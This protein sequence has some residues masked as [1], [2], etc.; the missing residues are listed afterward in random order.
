[1]LA[2]RLVA[3]AL[4]RPDSATFTAS[5]VGVGKVGVIVR[6]DSGLVVKPSAGPAIGV[7]D[8]GAEVA[9]WGGGDGV[10][11]LDITEGETEGLGFWGGE[12][13]GLV[14]LRLV[15]DGGGIDEGRSLG[16]MVGFV[17][18]GRGGILEGVALS[19]PLGTELGLWVREDDGVIVLRTVDGTGVG[20]SLGPMVGSGLTRVGRSVGDEVE[21]KLVLGA[22]E[23]LPSKLHCS[24]HPSPLARFPSSHDS[25]FSTAPF[26]QTDVP[27]RGPY[28]GIVWS[29]SYAPKSGAVPAKPSLTFNK[30]SPASTATD[31]SART[32][33][34][35]VTA[36]N[37]VLG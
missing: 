32:S 33:C 4:P 9:S 2:K 28:G 17:L 21:G 22:A 30:G 13:D 35:T 20:R 26:P 14:V 16:P 29:N 36:G 31:P 25:P 18:E 10:A 3:N 6:G 24:S 37:R 27:V 34:G 23:R 7:S 5:E 12:D 19:G 8:C 1:M 11:V 15:G